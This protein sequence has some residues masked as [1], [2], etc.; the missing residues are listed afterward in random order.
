[1]NAIG[2][3]ISFGMDVSRIRLS[4]VYF[5]IIMDSDWFLHRLR[6]GCASNAIE[7]FL[8]QLNNGKDSNVIST[9]AL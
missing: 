6:N 8:H 1:V 7:W 5:S 2:F 3:C 4:G 9:S